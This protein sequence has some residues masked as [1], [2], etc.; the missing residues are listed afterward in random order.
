MKNS[1][2]IFLGLVGVGVYLY[3]RNKKQMQMNLPSVINPAAPVNDTGIVAVDRSGVEIA[4]SLDTSSGGGTGENYNVRFAIN[5]YRNKLGKI[6][7]A[8]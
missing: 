4:Q 3:L 5:G 2:L 1:T 8:I 6:P 7:N